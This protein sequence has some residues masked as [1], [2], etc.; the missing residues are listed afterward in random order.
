MRCFLDTKKILEMRKKS[1]IYCM[2]NFNFFANCITKKY[3][4]RE[5]TLN[6]YLTPFFSLNCNYFV[7]FFKLYPKSR[8]LLL[9]IM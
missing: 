8:D 7:N 1:E 2:K 9:S 6:Q 4:E 5:K 3:C